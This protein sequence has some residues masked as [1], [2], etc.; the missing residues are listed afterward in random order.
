MTISEAGS[1][2]DDEL[3]RL[4]QSKRDEISSITSQLQVHSIFLDCESVVLY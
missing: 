4:Q 2:V 3:I 1:E